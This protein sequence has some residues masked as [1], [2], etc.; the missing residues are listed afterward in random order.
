MKKAADKP[1]DMEHRPPIVMSWDMS[2]NGKTMLLDAIAKRCCL[3]EFGGIT[4]H[5]GAYMVETPHG[6]ISFLDTP[7]HVLS[8]KCVARGA[9]H[10]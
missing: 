5:I 1:E 9:N 6:K 3:Q 7:G 4:Q 2:T 10:Y 8:L